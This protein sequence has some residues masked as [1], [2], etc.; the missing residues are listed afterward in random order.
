ARSA[1]ACVKTTAGTWIRFFEAPLRGD[2][3]RW[4][5]RCGHRLNPRIPCLAG[6]TRFRSDSAA[7]QARRLFPWGSSAE[8]QAMR[9]R[10]NR[11]VLLLPPRQDGRTP[12]A[13]SIVLCQCETRKPC[14]CA[15]FFAAGEVDRIG[16][17]KTRSE[18][19][20]LLIRAERRSSFPHTR[21]FSGPG[22]S[23]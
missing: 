22:E 20:P 10:P 23:G 12:S 18:T 5:A 9:G 6:H 17:R 11:P 4:Q 1:V 21:L 13:G 19:C 3:G 8:R 7:P 14:K 16:R 2:G 15:R